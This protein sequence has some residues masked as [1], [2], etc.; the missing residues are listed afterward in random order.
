MEYLLGK[1]LAKGDRDSGRDA[2]DLYREG[3]M[4]PVLICCI[5]GNPRWYKI[6][7]EEGFKPGAQLPWTIY[8]PLYFADQDWKKP[9]RCI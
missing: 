3:K 4:T 7:V 2:T 1:C 8:G 5:G 6:T 9:D